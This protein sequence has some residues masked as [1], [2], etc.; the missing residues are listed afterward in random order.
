MFDVERRAH[1]GI[2]ANSKKSAT[3]ISITTFEMGFLKR[4]AN[5]YVAYRVIDL[6]QYTASHGLNNVNN[7]GRIFISRTQHESKHET[8]HAFTGHIDRRT[9]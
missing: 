6:D 7:R 3:A 5:G 4:C 9:V 8:K 1:S 2:Y